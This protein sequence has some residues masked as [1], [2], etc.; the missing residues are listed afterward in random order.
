MTDVISL[1][2]EFRKIPETGLHNNKTATLIGEILT[3]Q[4]I[5]WRK[6]AQTSGIIA[7]IPGDRPEAIVFRADTDALDI[8]DL[9]D[10]PWKSI[11][12]GK[13]HACGH[14]GH[15]AMLLAAAGDINSRRNELKKSVRLIFQPGEEGHGGAAIMTREGAVSQE[16]SSIIPEEI[17]GLHLWTYEKSGVVFLSQ[18]PVFAA[19]CG[20]E[21]TIRGSS[22]HAAKRHE[23]SDPLE[24]A[25]ALV[26]ILHQRIKEASTASKP[27]L[28]HAGTI[29][30]GFGHNVVAEKIII[31]G[32]LRSSDNLAHDE[33]IKQTD[34]FISGFLERRDLAGEFR[35]FQKYGAVINDEKVTSRLHLASTLAGAQVN[36]C[37]FQM[38]GEDFSF[39]TD[40]IPGAFA[41]IGAGFEGGKPHHSPTF[42]FDENVLHLGV[43]I[44]KNLAFSV[45]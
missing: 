40:V 2:R 32:T 42:D 35:V 33:I 11:H 39:Y 29:S 7:D 37:D 17:F 20:F 10:K 9:I 23:V 21:I 41:L 3:S 34:T 18:G 44:W 38:I 31:R 25:C 24:A 14:D 1:R 43:E 30:G 26:T 36:K 6:S 16:K 45:V 22:V 5:S 12:Q 19:T 8:P 15:T 13:C 4:G 28:F 27:L